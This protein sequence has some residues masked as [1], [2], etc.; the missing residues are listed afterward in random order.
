MKKISGR[1]KLP[2][3][4]CQGI[5]KQPGAGSLSCVVCRGSGQVRAEQPYKLC[6]ECGGRGKKRGANLYCFLCHGKGVVEGIIYPSPARPPCS[7]MRKSVKIK[8]RRKGKFSKKKSARNAR[9][10]MRRQGRK[11]SAKPEIRKTEV[12]V[13]EERKSSP[14]PRLRRAGFFKKLLGAIKIL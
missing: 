13:K 8:K 9:K 12:A 5:G 1:N 6:K 11:K 2:C 7:K 3:A 4:F 10:L 14:A